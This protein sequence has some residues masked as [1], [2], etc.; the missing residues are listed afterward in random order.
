MRVLGTFLLAALF[1][2]SAFA[3]NI[4]IV[5][6]GVDILHPDLASVVWSNDGEVKGNRK[7][8]DNNEYIDDVN[9]WNFAE[10]NGKVIEYKYLNSFSLDPARFFEIQR[11]GFLGTVTQEDRDWVKSKVSDP[12]FVKEIGKFGNFVHGTHVAGISARNNSSARI[13]TL[14]LIPTESPLA[15]N[16]DDD[17]GLDPA[18]SPFPA[19]FRGLGDL[20]RDGLIK[21]VLG[22]VADQQ[23]NTF[24]TLS[25]YLAAKKADVANYSLGTN[26]AGISKI[27]KVI[28]KVAYSNE[29]SDADVA[30]YA[31]FM[32][33]KLT[34]DGTKFT[35]AAP[36]TLFVFA[37][38]NDGTDNDASPVSPANVKAPNSITVAATFG[39]QKLASF[40]N[41]G[42]TTVDVA[43]PGVSIFSSIPGNDHMYLSG[44]SQAAPL[45]TDIAGI[46]RDANAD[47]GVSETKRIIMETVDVKEFLKGKVKSSGI[48]NAARA[49]NA[50]ELS[51]RLPLKDAIAQAKTNIPDQ[52]EVLESLY[53]VPDSGIFVLPLPSTFVT[54]VL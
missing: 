48:V 20:I 45:V 19:N 11:K 2:N 26:M 34:T 24:L 44:T 31:K 6:S 5:D 22:A 38:G 30:T 8:D 25:K 9:G 21:G 23:I 18:N 52:A 4:A 39:T 16:N 12:A 32:I 13:M 51:L 27:V 10:N 1:A 53:S 7:D 43:A 49:K 47:L 17:A 36:E 29:P 50:A 41:Y 35:Q 40:S 54:P 37:S 46:I 33:N 15:G 3:S 42:A 28:L 14:K